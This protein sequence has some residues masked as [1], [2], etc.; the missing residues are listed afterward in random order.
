MKDWWKY[1]SVILLLYVVV[2]SLST[3]LAPG[4]SGVERETLRTGL[5]EPLSVYGYNTDFSSAE[6]PHVWLESDTSRFCVTTVTPTGGQTLEL[7]I[8]VPDSLPLSFLHLYV[9]YQGRILF[10]ANAFRVENAAKG[11]FQPD[12]CAEKTY[13][14][15]NTA[16]GFTFPNREILNET[17]RN[18]MFHVPMWF[19]MMLILLISVIY[20]IR[21]LSGFNPVHDLIARQ[22]VNVGLLF[23]ILGLLTGSLWARFT[24][25]H[26]WVDD[27]KLN[28]AAVTTLVYL[29][30]LVLRGSIQEEQNQARVAA[31]YNIFAFV[32]LIVMLLILPRMTESLHPGSGGNPAFSQYDLDSNLRKVFYPAVI[33][34]MGL[35]L[36]ILNLRIRLEKLRRKTELA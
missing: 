22:A 10:L 36:W 11:T 1:A 21:Y 6:A 24:W 12:A 32:I 35:S 30:Y 28:G 14:Y 33:G 17:I 3:P 29:A 4:I 9:S 31:V 8:E 2:V 23:G 26:W 13:T 16:T 25:M 7:Q 18:L 20:S 19:T 15:A 5:N 27:T 34:W